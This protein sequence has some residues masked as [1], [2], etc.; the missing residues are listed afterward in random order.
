[1]VCSKDLFNF[2]FFR[3]VPKVSEDFAKIIPRYYTQ[4][5]SNEAQG[6]PWISTHARLILF[7]LLALHSRQQR[8]RSFR[9]A[10][11]IETSGRTLFLR[12]FV[13]YFQ[14]IRFARSCL[15]WVHEPAWGLDRW[16]WRKVSRPLW[17]KCCAGVCNV[18][19]WKKCK[20]K[21]KASVLE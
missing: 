16:C 5:K 12:V 18:H 10:Q 14:P 15:Q 8:P 11:K 9:S 4:R 13:S 3:S 6:L 19:T 2:G 20:R 7:C 17:R 1:M 21:F